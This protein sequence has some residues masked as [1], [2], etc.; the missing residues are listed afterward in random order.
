MPQV[1]V[2]G[3]RA[4]DAQQSPSQGDPAREAVADEEQEQVMRRQGLKDACAKL[5]LKPEGL[6]PL[7]D[8]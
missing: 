4:C 8:C 2:Q 3:L 5:M 6:R 1:G 7:E